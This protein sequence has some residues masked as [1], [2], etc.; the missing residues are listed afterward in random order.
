MGTSSVSVVI[1]GAGFGGLGMAAALKR[2]G[3]DS[4]VVLEKEHEVGG[5]WRDNTYPGCG[6]DVPSHLYSF[7]FEKYR[8]ATSRYP[9]QP[10]ILRYLV[11]VSEKFDLRR[12]LRTATMVIA[13]DYDEAKCKWTVTTDTGETIVADAVI[14]AVGQL[15]RPKLPEIP[16]RQEFSGAA[17]HSARWDHDQEFSGRTVAL[18]GTGS[19]AAQLL[20]HVAEQARQVHVFQRTPNWVLP[21]PSAD[22]GTPTKTV[23]KWFPR[24]QTAYRSLVYLAADLALSP[25]ITRG[26]SA[27]PAR[28]IASWNLRRQVADPVL[29]AKLIP[30]YPIGCKRIV[31]DSSFYPALSRENVELVTEPIAEITGDG[32]RTGDG[33]HRPVDAIVYATGFRTTEFLV[34]MH[35][36]GKGGVRLADVWKDGAEA[37]LGIAVEGFPN[38][39][40]VHGPNTIL[41]H[42]SNVF[43]I[44]CQVRF[45]MKCLEMLP[46]AVELRADA[47]SDYRR[48][49]DTAVANTVW[50]AGCNSWYKT[51]SGRVT[52]P[53]PQSTMRYRRLLQQ[54]PQAAFTVG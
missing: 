8:S 34:P 48:W 28:W 44:E 6:C 39:F 31:I 51:E 9:A 43:M 23:F 17:F 38:F 25:V 40:L 36:R 47:M 4:F 11:G 26:W 3:I 29:R 41:G 53:W 50:P 45:I 35:V 24:A 54:N 7:S 49:L 12:H 19:S 46:G 21:K 5:I 16:G 10:E 52:N 18:I 33:A 27:R 14:S 13:A 37:Y 1:V 42:N 2:A 32:V 30:S 22:F 15:H 20:P